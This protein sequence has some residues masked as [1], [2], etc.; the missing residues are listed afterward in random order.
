MSFSLKTN[1]KCLFILFSHNQSMPYFSND[2]IH[3]L[4]LHIPKTGGMSIEKYFFEKYKIEKNHKSLYGYHHP[5]FNI[6]KLIFKNDNEH[7]MQHLTY[8]N[9]CDF[10]DELGVMNNDVSLQ[11]MTTVRN[12]YDRIMSDMFFFVVKTNITL[13][14]SKEDIE[15]EIE[16]YLNDDKYDY[17]NHRLPQCEFLFDKKGE[18]PK[19]MVVL[20]CETLTQDMQNIGFLDFHHHENQNRT[21]VKM[22]YQNLLSNDSIKRINEYYKKDFEIF[23]YDMVIV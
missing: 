1:I 20:K 5:C 18:I 11:M 3:L 2:Q 13:H 4:Y 21:G 15:R 23:G 10:S 9:I 14:S 19:N 6:N 12:P 7:T 22:C 8:K 17:D 16:K